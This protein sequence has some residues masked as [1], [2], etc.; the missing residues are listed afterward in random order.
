LNTFFLTNQITNCYTFKAPTK[1]LWNGQI[2]GF[3]IGY[4]AANSNQDLYKT[5]EA[6]DETN[7]YESHL[8]N[9]LRSTVYFAWVQ[10]FNAKGAGP[11]SDQVSVKTLA[12]VP[13]SAPILKVHSTTTNSITISWTL[14]TNFGNS[15]NQF[16]L[17][18]RIY[19]TQFNLNSWKEISI[20]NSEM[21]HTVSNLECGKSYEFYMTAHN[22]VGKSEPSATIIARTDG[23]PPLPPKLSDTLS[24]IGSHEVTV[25]LMSWK[26][27]QCPISHF[28]IKIRP[29]LTR[30]WNVI[31]SHYSSTQNYVIKNLIPNTHYDLETTAHSSAGSTQSLYEFSTINITSRGKLNNLLKSQFFRFNYLTETVFKV[32]SG[33]KASSYPIQANEFNF[34]DY[35]IILPIISSTIVVIVIIVV[36]CCICSRDASFFFHTRNRRQGLQTINSVLF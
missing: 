14:M 36:S 25:N 30:N 35:E 1:N 5:I 2:S 9:L 24:N 6:I 34:S 4:R 28:S 22:S 19:S 29:K 20:T 18:Q 21:R 15:V 26:G 32:G 17:Y 10:A 7:K 12:D 31:T 11:R 33:H 13:P 3:Y 27:G 16:T 8:T 23:E